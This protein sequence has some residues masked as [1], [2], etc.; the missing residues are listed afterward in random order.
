MSLGAVRKQCIQPW[1]SCCLWWDD[2]GGTD[3]AHAV[4]VCCLRQAGARRRFDKAGSVCTVVSVSRC[5]LAG[6]AL[7]LPA[8]QPA[9][10]GSSMVT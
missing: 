5:E 4:H 7:L 6:I 9:N 2:C 10:C 1:H 8:K 3:A